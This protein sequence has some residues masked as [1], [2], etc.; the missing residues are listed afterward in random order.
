MVIPLTFGYLSVA[1]FVAKSSKELNKD[2]LRSHLASDH[3]RVVRA[4]VDSSKISNS[5]HVVAGIPV[6]LVECLINDFLALCIG[7]STDGKQK[8]VE[9]DI[10]V[11]V[12][13][14]LVKRQK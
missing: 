1:I 7:P 6:E 10:A 4:V 11:T 3:L 13:V 8:F 12:Q 9:V 5:D 2:L 14:E